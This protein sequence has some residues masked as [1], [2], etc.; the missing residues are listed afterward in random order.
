MP[1]SEKTTNALPGSAP[2]S[3]KGKPKPTQRPDTRAGAQAAKDTETGGREAAEERERKTSAK[4]PAA[5]GSKAAPAAPRPEAR[6][7]KLTPQQQIH[8][9]RARRRK[10][11]ERLGLGAIALLVIVAIAFVSWRVVV[12]NQ[13][14]ARQASAHA[15]A[16]ATAAVHATA[17]QTALNVL[18]PDTPP[19]VPGKTITTKD[20]LQYIDIKVG[21]GTAAKEGDTINARYVGWN[22][23]ANCQV[24]GKCQF[25]SSYYENIQQNKDPM[26]TV[27]FQLVQ[28]GL[29]Q[30]WVEGIVGMQPGGKRRLIIPAALAYKDQAQS[31][32]GEQPIPANATLIF[33]VE[34]VS[35]GNT[36]TPTPT[37]GS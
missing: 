15:A 31:G 5:K 25:D 18:S 22:V 17:T 30:G 37:P 23:P 3:P 7:R 1:S 10:R 13:E 11:N 12:T 28:G 33:D 6:V 8:A 2:R 36:P 20:G 27:Q 32:G 16:T 26:T 21:T 9:A 24:V 14:N 29:I 4:L 19:A 35:I 34:L